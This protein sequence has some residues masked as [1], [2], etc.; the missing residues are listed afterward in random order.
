MS[1]KTSRSAFTIRDL[2]VLMT[3]VGLSL[4]CLLPGMNSP[5]QDGNANGC[6]NNMRNLA[7]SIISYEVTTGAYPGYV[8]A[9]PSAT[10]GANVARPLVYMISPQ[11]ERRDIYESFLPWNFPGN[12]MENVGP[13]C[14]FALLQCPSNPQTRPDATAYVFNCGFP[15]PTDSFNNGVFTHRCRPTRRAPGNT[16]A[17]ITRHDGTTNTVMISESLDAHDAAGLHGGWK[18]LSENWVGFLWHDLSDAQ[19]TPPYNINGRR[20][21]RGDSASPAWARPSSNHYQVVNVAF[22]DGHVRVINEKISYTVWTQLMTPNGA[23]A[24]ASSDPSSTAGPR[25][26]GVHGY[27]LKDGDIP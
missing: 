27:R 16:S 24:V 13:T 20:G 17:F 19:A 18:S 4:S 15:G 21:E 8:D 9:M 5:R 14:H 10:G 6:R 26:N 11:L 2:L 22:C 7:L 23:G 1:R 25:N 3:V 12:L